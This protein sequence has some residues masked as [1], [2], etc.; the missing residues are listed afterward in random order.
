MLPPFWTTNLRSWLSWFK[1]AE[2]AFQLRNIADEKSRFYNCLHALPE[3][4]VSLIS[5]LVEANPLHVNPSTELRRRLLAAHQKT[6][7]Q[8]VEQLFSLPPLTAQ[9]PSELL[10]EMLRFCP[11]GQENTFSNCLLLSK[12]PRELR[13]L[14]LEGDMADK[15]VVGLFTAQY[16]KHTHDMVAALTAGSLQEQGEEPTV[17]TVRP[18]ASSGQRGNG[19]RQRGGSWRGKKKPGRSGGGGSGLQVSHRVS[20]VELARLETGLYFC[21]RAKAKTCRAPC[22]WS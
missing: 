22:T 3:A 12:L 7:I 18:G 10:A 14:F 5:D 6:N 11:R 15:Q 9:K 13:I 4:T 1:S 8:W 17:T 19:G 20:H 21:Y 16:S 2:R